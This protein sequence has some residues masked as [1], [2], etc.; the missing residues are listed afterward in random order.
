MATK[1]GSAFLEVSPQLNMKG[2]S[3][4]GAAY[5]N[6]F[7][8][9]MQTAISAGAVAVGN[10]LADLAMQA[11]NLISKFIG[12]SVQIGAEFEKSMS[13]VAATMGVSVNDIGDLTAT[14]KEMGRTTTYSATQAAEGLNILAMSGYDADQS[15]EMLEDVL[16]LAAAGSMD[17]A[18]AA[19]YVSGAM[20]GFN[21]V[22]KD[23]QYYADLMAQGATLANT[24]VSQLGDAMSSGAATA[25]AYG[26][27]ADSMTIALLRLAEQGEVGS[28]A[29]TA[30]AAAM[31]DIYTPSVQAAKA[32]DKLGV[33]AYDADGN[34]RDFNEVV[35]E[36]DAALAG[37]SEEEANAYK[38]MIFGI[39][40]LNA[41]N[42]MVVTGTDKQDAWAESLASAS[43]GMGAAAQ[44]YAT[45]TDNF[46]GAT[47]GLGSALEGLQIALFEK[48][49]PALRVVV[50][51]ATGFI[52]AVTSIV[53]GGLPEEVTAFGSMFDGVFQTIGAV[54]AEVSAFVSEQVSTAWP[55]VEQVV[56]DVS[57]RVQKVIDT[58]WPFVQKL[59]ETSMKAITTVMQVAWPAIQ[60]IIQVVM[61]TVGG[62]VST[63]WGAITAV[64]DN[65]INFITSAISAWSI[66][67]DIVG[68]IFD[69][70]S[71]A[72][73]EP[74]ETAKEIVK[75]ICEAIAGFF[76]NLNITPPHIPM[77]HFSISPEGWK[78]DDLLKGSIPSLGIEWYAK[79][80][81]VDGATL[82]GAG[83]A[84]PE[85]ILPQQGGLMDEFADAVASRND[86]IL[87]KWLDRNLGPIIREYAPVLGMRDFDRL[88]RSAVR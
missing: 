62:I 12:D 35:N 22:T 41:Y 53:T 36:L 25:A 54:V 55:F 40:G 37:M 84:G 85:M 21:D 11:A 69:A 75:G 51:A 52:S 4:D 24:S 31:K 6:T 27:S 76:S 47:S 50:E 42:K 61:T 16:H 67:V 20:K 66:I 29:G 1:V 81:I 2:G 19:A 78:I 82:I 43:D 48:V 34:A 32:M 13:Q 38:Q 33:S 60:G 72:I 39:Q 88:A 44:Q 28:A 3:T 10:I 77:P 74:I 46:A 8:G 73:T 56:T 23:S 49:E 15:M 26:Q 45:M 65:A 5:G 86:A 58:V 63:A 30:L 71:A 9:S 70:V 7:S 83:E 80:G 14:A 79:G 64:I 18:D 87:I 68:G 17:M 57:T 59:M